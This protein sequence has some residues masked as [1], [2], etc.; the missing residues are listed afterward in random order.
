MPIAPTLSTLQTQLAQAMQKG[1]AAEP[2]VVATDIIGAIAQTASA[3][4]QPIGTGAIAVVP[5]GQSVATAVYTG[6]L[7]LNPPATT[8]SA[9]GLAGAIVLIAPQVPP[10]GFATLTSQL[11]A[12]LN[13][14]PAADVQVIAQEW[15]SAVIAYYTAGGIV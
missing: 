5:A 1:P 13:K 8:L 2:P 3:G 7:L 4:L 9:T 6:V 15:A 10:T 12:S 14:G 11:E